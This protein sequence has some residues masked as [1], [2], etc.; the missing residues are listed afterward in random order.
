M[1]TKAAV[2]GASLLVILCVVL[3]NVNVG[4]DCTQ[5]CKMVYGFDIAGAGTN[6]DE[7]DPPNCIGPGLLI[8]VPVGGGG[9][10]TEYPSVGRHRI[11]PACVDWCPDHTL[12]EWSPLTTEECGSWL[13][14]TIYHCAAS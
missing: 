3:A 4:D 13:P 8:W 6:C 7:Y 10:C 12:D 9:V 1:F 14:K 11:C 5:K 2:V